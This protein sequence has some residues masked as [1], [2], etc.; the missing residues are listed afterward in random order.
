MNFKTFFILVIWL[1]ITFM[2]YKINPFLAHFLLGLIVIG[3]LGLRA[4][5]LFRENN[6]KQARI[7]VGAMLIGLIFMFIWYIRPLLL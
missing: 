2:V 6:K 3:S 1:I 5:K 4:K 7:H